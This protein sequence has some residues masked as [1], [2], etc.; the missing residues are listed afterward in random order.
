MKASLPRSRFYSIITQCSSPQ[1]AAHIQTTFLSTTLTN[2]HVVYI[3]RG[4]GAPT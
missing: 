4:L 2:Q 3:F 1:T